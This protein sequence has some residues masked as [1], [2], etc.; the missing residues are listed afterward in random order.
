MGAPEANAPLSPAATT[1]SYEHEGDRQFATT[2]ARGLE[3][4]RCFTPL[5]P[6]LGNKEISVRTGLPK[7]TVSRLTYTL[8]K[9][10]YLRHNMRLGKYQLGSAVLSIGYPLLASMSVRQV[11]R[12]FMKELADY[13][14]GSVSMGIRDRLNMVYV[15]SS[16]N[17]NTL[18][19][20]PDIG[21]AVPIA[22]AAIGRAF[23]AACTP[24]EREAVLNQIK[25]KEPE[26]HRKF[27]PAIDKS[28][29]DIRSRGFCVS[30]GELR[31]EVSG[32]AVPMRRTVD[33]EII[34]FNCGV[35]SFALKKGQLEE[36]IGPRL[37]AMVRNVEA[38]LGIH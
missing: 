13:T 31:R 38:A 10:G 25:V 8:T 1:Y 3:V 35:P 23:L 4:L 34:A 29:E 6:M 2:L 21:T 5:E 14:G 16:R 36:D 24:A 9:L 18:T 26:L 7:P 15:E 33:G 27:R 28:L 30:I 22:Q 19:M 32:V 20:L 37:V 11:A 12:P 17:G